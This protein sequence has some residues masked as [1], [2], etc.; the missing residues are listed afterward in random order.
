MPER[1]P[2]H[3]DRTSR[4]VVYR[5]ASTSPGNVVDRYTEIHRDTARLC[6]WRQLVHVWHFA[7][8]TPLSNIRADW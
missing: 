7:I 5:I 1:C 8:D 4:L 3:D 2:D 6:K